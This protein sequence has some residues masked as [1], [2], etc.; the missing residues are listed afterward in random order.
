MRSVTTA[1]GRLGVC[2]QFCAEM[3]DA[4]GEQRLDGRHRV[5]TALLARFGRALHLSRRQLLA[6]TAVAERKAADVKAGDELVLAGGESAD[7]HPSGPI[8]LSP[9]NRPEGCVVL[10]AGL[11][12]LT[13]ML[14]R[15][16][17]QQSILQHATDV[18]QRALGFHRAILA[19]KQPRVDVFIARACSGSPPD[20]SKTPFGFRL[21]RS[22]DL[23]NA[24]LLRTADIY[25]RDA[26]EP[27]LQEALPQWFRRCCPDARSF[28]LLC[29]RS[30]DEPIAFFY[31]DH[32]YA[33]APRL[34][35]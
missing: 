9:T 26:S 17:P 3:V 7:L 29:V 24:A 2:A 13:R 31:A 16:A 28:L 11:A 4:A 27:R 12:A 30:G 15:H 22:P 21:S 35:R 34:T 6:A 10:G 25:I 18:L 1:E 20:T 19:V 33:G 14:E 8:T 32:A 23:F 5:M